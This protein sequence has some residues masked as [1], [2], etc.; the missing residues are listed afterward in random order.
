MVVLQ[1]QLRQQ[2]LPNGLT[3]AA[4]LSRP[5]SALSR[6]SSNAASAGPVNAAVAQKAP[7]HALSAMPTGPGIRG[8]VTPPQQAGVASRGANA[9]PVRTQ[10]GRPGTPGSARED[11]PAAASTAA[12]AAAAALSRPTSAPGN[13]PLLRH[14]SGP[15]SVAATPSGDPPQLTRSLSSAAPGSSAR[16]VDK[17]PPEQPSAPVAPSYRN[18]AAGKIRGATPAPTALVA[19]SAPA[20]SSLAAFPPIGGPPQIVTQQGG[21]SRGSSSQPS[22][23]VTPSSQQES[24]TSSPATP[25]KSAPGQEQAAAKEQPSPGGSKR[26]AVYAPPMHAASP[27]R[28]PSGSNESGGKTEAAQPEGKGIKFGSVTADVLPPRSPRAEVPAPG[29]GGQDQQAQHPGVQRAQQ[30]AVGMTPPHAVRSAAGGGQPHM[31]SPGLSEDF[32]HLSLINDLLDDD[33]LGMGMGAN[34]NSGQNPQGGYNAVHSRIP[35]QI[36]AR[37]LHP[38]ASPFS[39]A[40]AAN[41]TEAERGGSG[42]SGSGPPQANGL[43]HHQQKPQQAAPQQGPPQ[44]HYPQHPGNNN[45]G[46]GGGG[47]KNGPPEYAS[48]GGMQRAQQLRHTRSLPPGVADGLLSNGHMGHP[49]MYWVPNSGAYPPPGMHGVNVNGPMLDKNG[50][51]GGVPPGYQMSHANY[52]QFAPAQQPL[53]PQHQ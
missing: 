52:G 44:H 3:S 47:H 53:P 20:P 24:P 18:A 7:T 4:P 16:V 12:A 32:P 46:S 40:S 29:S 10:G 9:Y 14:I 26:G 49:P 27:E 22:P 45:A 38:G 2:A 13:G 51:Q 43:S 8:V 31:D 36:L 25:R 35:P 11:P 34:G 23:P 33:L 39:P 48:A 5:S 6:T 42:G 1:E 17:P 41:R 15:I 28:A 50:M 21:S 30:Q 19:S 37:K